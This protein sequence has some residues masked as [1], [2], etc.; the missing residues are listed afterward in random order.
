MKG[1]G[2]CCTY[3][4]SCPDSQSGFDKLLDEEWTCPICYEW[5]NDCAITNC[6]HLFCATCLNTHTSINN[7][8]PI[9][10]QPII[11]VQWCSFDNVLKYY[12]KELTNACSNNE[13]THCYEHQKNIE[14]HLKDS[15]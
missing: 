9:C 2:D 10:R 13:V 12:E 1:S 11:S 5:K 4:K 3:T 15:K 7:T 8:C 14:S 6:E